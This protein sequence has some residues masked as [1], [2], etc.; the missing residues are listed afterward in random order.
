MRSALLLGTAWAFLAGSSL[1]I[2]DL[3]F[4]QDMTY[5]EFKEATTTLNYT[6]MLALS[7]WHNSLTI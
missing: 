3:L 6:G 5:N 4:Y 7:S 1:A 2:E